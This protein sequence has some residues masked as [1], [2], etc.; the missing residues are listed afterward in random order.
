MSFKLPVNILIKI[1][2]LTGLFFSCQLYAQKNIS[3]HEIEVGESGFL[4]LYIKYTDEHITDGKLQLN[5]SSVKIY[6]KISGRLNSYETETLKDTL[7]T[8]EDTVQV[9]EVHFLVDVSNQV[10]NQQLDTAIKKIIQPV[11]EKYQYLNKQNGIDIY[12][13]TFSNKK[14]ESQKIITTEN[15]PT[16]LKK[17]KL[18]NNKQPDLFRIYTQTIKQL[19]STSDK[20][21]LIL[22]SSS[23][24]YTSVENNQIYKK[25]LPYT[26]EDVW[27]F[28]DNIPSGLSVFAIG[29][30]DGLINLRDLVQQGNKSTIQSEDTPQKYLE[31]FDSQDR[32]LSNF[33]VQII[34]KSDI[35]KGEKREYS[36]ALD[37]GITQ[38]EHLFEMGSIFFP[39]RLQHNITYEDWLLPFLKGLLSLGVLLFIFGIIVPWNREKIFKKEYVEKYIQEKSIVRNDPLR[40]EPIKAGDLI[41][42]KCNQIIPFKTWKM[43]GWQCPNYPECMSQS[44]SG[45]GEP[46]ANDFFSM[47]G[48]YL[49]LNWVLFGI[50]GGFLAWVFVSLFFKANYQGLNE[51]IESWLTEQTTLNNSRLIAQNIG[52]SFLVG[53]ASGAGLTS[54]LSLMEERRSSNKYSRWKSVGKILLR[55]LVG[56]VVSCIVFAVGAVLHYLIGSFSSGLI[57]W[58]L[59]GIGLGWILSY[60]SSIPIRNG[61]GGG[62]LASIISF[63]VFWLISVF[64]NFSFLNANLISLLILGGIMGYI[65][66]TVVAM[67]EDYELKIIAP[68]GFQ[69]TIPISKW[70]KSKVG[71]TIGRLP[72]SFIFIKW[73]DSGVEPNHAKLF[74]ENGSI[75]I[76]PIG[77]VLLDGKIINKPV[78]LKNKDIFE[79]GRAGITQFQYVEK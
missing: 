31:I 1:V 69:R 13:N 54:M 70:L 34:P 45:A 73:E 33:R 9:S 10:S 49:K 30:K 79:L 50:L 37:D 72:S 23:V 64:L 12:L 18:R 43:I 32:I 36:I 26:E 44:C 46:Q 57:A 42:K 14:S 55:T 51:L 60:K 27:R 38:D 16:L 71:V 5:R 53:I 47:Q 75:Y 41:V 21:M 61:I 63:I 40:N 29:F 2:L 15:L 6:E 56:I 19:K 3:I 77:E 7:I 39:V 74:A 22:I 58:M 65:V 20:K 28:R 67:L 24:N 52:N 8:S 76:Q 17:S 62:L 11:I 48:I 78:K 25:Q 35:F 66:V 4:N 59:F 68:V